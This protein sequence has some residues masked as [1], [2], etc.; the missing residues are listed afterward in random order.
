M[1]DNVQAFLVRTAVN[2]AIDNYRRERFF[3]GIASDVRNSETAPLQDEIVAARAS[4]KRAEEGLSR[5]NPRTR[6]IL[7]MHRLE[8]MKYRD[9]AKQLAI[10]ESAVEKHIA[11]GTLFLGKW[12]EG[13]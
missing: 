1:V 12:M 5:L 6:E 2:I 7:L 3:A 10:S 13:W 8:N 4:L 9:I 11:K